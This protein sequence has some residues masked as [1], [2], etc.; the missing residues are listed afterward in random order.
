MLDKISKI[1]DWVYDHNVWIYGTIVTSEVLWF[2]NK[3]IL[4]S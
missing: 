3:K 2:I 4:N 1:C